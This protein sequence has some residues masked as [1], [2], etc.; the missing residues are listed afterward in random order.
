MPSVRNVCAAFS[1]WFLLGSDRTATDSD[2]VLRAPAHSYL[3]SLIGPPFVERRAFH[4]LPYELKLSAGIEGDRVAG[5]HSDVGDFG[6]PAVL[7]A[8]PVGRGGRVD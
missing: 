4:V 8:Q 7:G 3:P 6:D 5:H 1:R 2:R